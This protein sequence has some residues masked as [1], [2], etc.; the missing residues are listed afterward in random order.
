LDLTSTSQNDTPAVA[1]IE[2]P[3]RGAELI[4]GRPLLERMIRICER[5]GVDRFFI[6]RSAAEQDGFEP[7]LGRFAGDPRIRLVDSFGEIKS[8]A[9]EWRDDSQCVALRGNIVFSVSQLRDL[10]ARQ[11]STRQAPNGRS[12]VVRLGSANGDPAA[13]VSVG[14]LRD[15]IGAN[16]GPVVSG[17]AST[18]TGLPFALDGHPEDREAAER[19]IASTLRHDTARTDGVMAR[20]FDRKISWRLSY[21]LANTAV[22][23]NQVTIA[24]TAFG[25]F[26]AWMFAQPG[27]WLPLL[28][29]L[30]F[31]VSITLDG[32]DGE[33]ARLK[34]AETTAGARLDALTDNL[35]HIAIFLG[36]SIGCYRAGHNPAYIYTLFVLLG[37][38]G[39]CAISVNRAMSVSAA[40]AEAFIRKVDRMTGRDFAYLVFFLALIN[41]LHYFIIG[42]AIGTYL[43]ALGLWWTTTRWT[44][45]NSARATGG[46]RLVEGT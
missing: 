17:V 41:R 31:V 1:L 19:V 29:S 32:V 4:F 9:G 35:V 42:A 39:L 20:I 8:A 38:F 6:Q 44:R 23:P 22:T 30:M 14:P 15:F 18:I 45:D 21:R 24:N 16:S 5:A 27:Y 37:G 7:V 3:S 33:L 34:M 2:A 11:A 12:E 40:G 10:M 36:I 28:A 43:F 13:S 25:M 26:I 46:D